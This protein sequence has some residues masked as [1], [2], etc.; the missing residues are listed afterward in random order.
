MKLT[1]LLLVLFRRGADRGQQDI[2]DNTALHYAEQRGHTD[3]VRILKSY[4][5]QRHGSAMSLASRVSVSMAADPPALDEQG[6][7]IFR[8]FSRQFSLS[9]ESST[10]A[11]AASSS[12]MNRLPADG[13]AQSESP[14]G[15]QEEVRV[16]EARGDVLEQH[17][18]GE[19]TRTEQ[20]SSDQSEEQAHEVGEVNSNA[21]VY[22][23]VKKLFLL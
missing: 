11:A 14:V 2:N 4:G 10:A 16:Q 13:Q 17:D 12:S 21:S 22:Y 5:L 15:D 3:C 6:H 20:R 23:A 9:R 18:G 19:V 7:V 1:C 8:M